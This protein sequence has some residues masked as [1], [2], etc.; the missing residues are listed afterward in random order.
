MRRN[1][2][3]VRN[4]NG[5]IK[6]KQMFIYLVSIP[7]IGLY[8]CHEKKSSYEPQKMKTEVFWKLF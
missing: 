1:S 3:N 5:D 8:Q 6:I 7:K 2:K 4:E